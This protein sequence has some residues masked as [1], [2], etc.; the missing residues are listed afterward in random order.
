MQGTSRCSASGASLLLSLFSLFLA[1]ALTDGFPRPDA[2]LT[3]QSAPPMAA[4]ADDGTLL[5]LQGQA[6]HLVTPEGERRAILPITQEAKR[7]F[8]HRGLNFLYAIDDTLICFDQSLAERWRRK[9]PSLLQTPLNGENLV[10]PCAKGAWV[11]EESSGR[12]LRAW[13]AEKAVVRVFSHRGEFLISQTDSTLRWRPGSPPYPLFPFALDQLACSPGDSGADLFSRDGCL[14]VAGNM[15]ML[16]T[17]P[18]TPRWRRDLHAPPVDRVLAMSIDGAPHWL[19]ASKGRTL[20]LLDA[21]GNER[22][23]L[24]L[25]DRPQRLA[26][27]RSGGVF[28][29]LTSL[30]VIAFFQP[31]EGSLSTQEVSS[32]QVEVLES[33]NW[34]AFVGYDGRI[35]FFRQS[36]EGGTNNGG[37]P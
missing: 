18:G 31:K 6:L 22:V 36:P 7:V 23:H 2:I 14:V 5:M 20:I 15:A 24:P 25:A 10:L 33:L 37:F 8:C 32:H 16:Y 29:S 11:L 34:I 28:L 3:L 1:F 4:L 19:L 26:A 12:T 13:S 17:R 21:K 9:L 35:L 30:P 27:R